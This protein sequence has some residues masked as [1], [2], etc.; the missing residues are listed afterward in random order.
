MEPNKEESSQKKE[1]TDISSL[2]RIYKFF[3]D[4]LKMKNQICRWFLFKPPSPRGIDNLLI[5]LLR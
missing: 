1:K 2:L 3:N 5:F 4:N